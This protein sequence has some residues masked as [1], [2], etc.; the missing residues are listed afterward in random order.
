MALSS[1]RQ[2]PI[3]VDLESE[4]ESAS[5]KGKRARKIAVRFLS[6]QIDFFLSQN[7]THQNR[8]R[9]VVSPLGW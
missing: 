4:F 7:L 3:V 5:R 9:I 2:E 6:I 1:G 8:T